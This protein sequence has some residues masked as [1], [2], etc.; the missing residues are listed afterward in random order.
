MGIKTGH[1]MYLTHRNVEFE[2]QGRK[3]LGRKV[4]ELVLD[5][6]EFIKQAK[7][8]PLQERK[9]PRETAQLARIL[10]ASNTHCQKMQVLERAVAAEVA[11]GANHV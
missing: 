4:A 2:R 10:T 9:P 7:W 3:L 11:S 5:G 8:T 6:S 1:R